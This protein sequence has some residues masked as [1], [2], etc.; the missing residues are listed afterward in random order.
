MMKLVLTVLL[1]LAILLSNE[2]WWR[3]RHPHGELSRKM[4]HIVVGSFVAFWPFYLSWSQI[5][6][7]SIAFF[8]VVFIS[9]YFNLFHAIHSVQRPTIGE[10]FFALAVGSV[11][12]ITHD[13]WIFM[14]ALLQMSLADGLAAVFGTR[15]A[16]RAKYS[17]LGHTK[18]F[19]GS[20][21]FLVVSLILMLV[22]SVFAPGVEFTYIL[23]LVA[24]LTTVV[25]NFSI[26]GLD[27][28]LVPVITAIA[29]KL[30]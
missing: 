26:Y 5:E 24:L 6:L 4:V 19:V 29:L 9:K 10:L 13:K 28:F 25:E 21:T 23:V 7:L 2:Y 12:L 14:I 8:I 15:Y 17:I 11:A 1:V 20:L 16:K 3:H 27:N 22:Y 18:S 30:A